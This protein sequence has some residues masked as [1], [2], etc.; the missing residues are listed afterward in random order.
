MVR[1]HEGQRALSTRI[2]EVEECISVHHIR[3]F[4]HRLMQLESRMGNTGGIIGDTL[5][6]CLMKL[7]QCTADLEDLRARM[8]EEDWYHD[9]SE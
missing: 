7:N 8:R 6:H 3:E 1:L 9:L 4:V 5:R 2:S